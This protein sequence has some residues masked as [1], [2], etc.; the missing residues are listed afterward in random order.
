MLL[1][2]YN[3]MT[4]GNPGTDERTL[5]EAAIAAPLVSARRRPEWTK[6]TVRE[7]GQAGID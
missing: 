3:D 7:V 1:S 2:L 6:Q 4:I 5:D